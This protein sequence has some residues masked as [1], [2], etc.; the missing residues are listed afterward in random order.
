M[1]ET[2]DYIAITRL[3]AAYADAV[4]T[5]SW[6]TLAALFTGDAPVSVNTMTNPVVS[7]RGGDDVAGFIAG[8]IERFVFFEFVALNIAAHFDGDHARGRVFMCELRQDRA[9]NE[10]SR[11]FGLY[12]D[13]YVRTTD[14]WR[15]A[16]RDYQSL[17]RT[18]GEV[19]ALPE[20]AF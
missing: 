20:L 15:F 3:H 9:T 10:F 16:T 5:R 13:T 7:L 11:A 2:D 6:E 4:N 12:Q 14:G 1:T 17:A 19:F 18:G 8:A